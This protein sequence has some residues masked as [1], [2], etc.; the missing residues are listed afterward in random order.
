MAAEPHSVAAGPMVPQPYLVRSRAR[1]TADT[2][3]LELVPS[4]GGPIEPA[5]GQFAMLTAYGVGEVPISLSGRGD[6]GSLGD[7]ANRIDGIPMPIASDE[8]DGGEIDGV[9]AAPTAYSAG[10][11]LRHRDFDRGLVLQGDVQAERVGTQLVEG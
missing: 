5:P 4:A 10:E 3:T 7:D 8:D 1:E 9:I 11:L 6:E 2:W